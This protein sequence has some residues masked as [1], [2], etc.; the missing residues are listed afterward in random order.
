MNTE[1]QVS[2]EYLMK[3]LQFTND[4]TT[5]REMQSEYFRTRNAETLKQCKTLERA[6]DKL[7]RDL[8]LNTGEKIHPSTSNL[9][10]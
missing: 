4:Y 3:V 2:K 10:Q 8:H 9:F 5:M 1:I 7:N 6:L